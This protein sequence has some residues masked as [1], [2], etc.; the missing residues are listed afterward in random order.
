MKT[1]RQEAVIKHSGFSAICKLSSRWQGQLEGI[2]SQPC[3]RQR[4]LP[5]S[6]KKTDDIQIRN[7]HLLHTQT[8]MNI[9][10]RHVGSIKPLKNK[11]YS[12]EIR[13]NLCTHSRYY[14]VV[15]LREKNFIRIRYFLLQARA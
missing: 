1:C 8:R 12:D 4:F 9:I 13:R 3:N 5:P 10:F 7:P 2:V 15:F 6:V 11:L 14:E